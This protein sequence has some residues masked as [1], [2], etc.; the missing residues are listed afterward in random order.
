M[1]RN[2]YSALA[3]EGLGEAYRTSVL[4][5]IYKGKKISVQQ[6]N[7]RSQSDVS[8]NDAILSRYP[9]NKNKTVLVPVPD[10]GQ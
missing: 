5:K 4:N 9:Q 2:Q 10:L 7:S 8:E 3:L 1:Q 6:P